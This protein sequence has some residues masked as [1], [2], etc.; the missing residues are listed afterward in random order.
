MKTLPEFIFIVILLSI[1]FT[2]SFAQNDTAFSKHN[3]L[4]HSISTD[5]LLPLFNAFAV[6]YE[7]QK[8]EKSSFILGFWYGKA[9]ET[10]PKMI[11]YPG[12]TVNIS[13]IFAYRHYFWKGLH[14]EYQ[15]Y[16]GYTKYYEEN[17]DRFYHSFNLFNEFRA[18]YK[19]NF[20]IYRMP[21]I[22]NLQF[23]VGFTIY[24]TNEPETFKQIRKQDPVFYIFYPNIYI[25]IRF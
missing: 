15:L 23:P 24:D 7:Y 9:T 11:E 2:E 6:I 5:P 1:I 16:P 3:K 20:H 22:L 13:P 17:E 19:F 18:G 25:G 10:Y 14:V 21:I 4:K 8:T 12:Y